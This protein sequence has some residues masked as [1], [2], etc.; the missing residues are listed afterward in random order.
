MRSRS[1]SRLYPDDREHFLSGNGF[2]LAIRADGTPLVPAIT[3]EER[4]ERK[5]RYSPFAG[6]VDP[7][8]RRLIPGPP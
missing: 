4:R 6:L 8:T 7:R 3:R 1:R 5:N 2:G